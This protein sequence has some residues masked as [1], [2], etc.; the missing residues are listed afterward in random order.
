MLNKESILV[1]ELYC[2]K[3]KVKCKSVSLKPFKS[4]IKK[5]KIIPGYRGQP[6]PSAHPEEINE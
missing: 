5:K 6:E 3:Q 4:I 2:N 1:T